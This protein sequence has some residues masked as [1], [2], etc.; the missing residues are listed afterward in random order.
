MI[1]SR[2]NRVQFHQ[3]NDVHLVYYPSFNNGDI[4]LLLAILSPNAHQ[5]AKNRE[6]MYKLGVIAEGFRNKY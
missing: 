2:I 4:F 3:K 5:Q 1:K 6:I